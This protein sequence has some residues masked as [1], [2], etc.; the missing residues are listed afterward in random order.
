[1]IVR[2]A[3]TT[4]IS[5]TAVLFLM[6]AEGCATTGTGQR[7]SAAQRDENA[8]VRFGYK[9]GTT[10]MA[11]CR[12]SLYKERQQEAAQ[13]QAVRCARERERQRQDTSG[14]GFAQGALDALNMRQACG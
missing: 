6:G 13:R 10:A 8:C 12:M 2:K 14:G 11:D 7:I 4:I 5:L 9:L 1:M 3:M